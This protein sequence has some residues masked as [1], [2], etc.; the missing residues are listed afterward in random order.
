MYFSK[1]QCIAYRNTECVT[2]V[3]WFIVQATGTKKKAK[4]N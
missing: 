1:K 4:R 2:V 3:K